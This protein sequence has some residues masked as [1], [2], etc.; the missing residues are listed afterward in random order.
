MHLKSRLQ[1]IDPEWELHSQQLPEKIPNLW[2]KFVSRELNVDQALEIL[3]SKEEKLIS[4]VEL[5]SHG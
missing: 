2:D 3:L 4:N 1:D 5:E